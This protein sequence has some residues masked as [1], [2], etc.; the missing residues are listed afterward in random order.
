VVNLAGATTL[1]GDFTM[2][3]TCRAVNNSAAVRGGVLAVTSASKV[4]GVTMLGTAEGNSAGG[5]AYSLLYSGLSQPGGF[6]GCRVACL[7][8]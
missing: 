6:V 8:A 5:H 3:R 2:H 4:Q 7:E 1:S